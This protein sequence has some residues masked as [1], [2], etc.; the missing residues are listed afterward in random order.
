MNKVDTESIS[1]YIITNL[2]IS[3]YIRNLRNCCYLVLY[4]LTTD[5]K[6]KHIYFHISSRKT[7]VPFALYNLG[8]IVFFSHS[9]SFFLSFILC[10]VAFFLSLCFSKTHRILHS[11]LHGTQKLKYSNVTLSV[12]LKKGSILISRS[13]IKTVWGV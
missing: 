1:F 2:R 6:M 11:L 7:L 13:K 8:F 12:V 10:L 4:C 3:S 9:C 5:I